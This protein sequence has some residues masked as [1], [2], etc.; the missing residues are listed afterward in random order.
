[1][2][3]VFVTHSIEEA[4]YVGDRVGILV[5]RK[6]ETS[7]R[8]AELLLYPGH[9]PFESRQDPHYYEACGALRQ[10]FSESRFA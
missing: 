9:R 4:V 6:E 2:A 5:P 8:G 10:K 1:M 7:D 3:T